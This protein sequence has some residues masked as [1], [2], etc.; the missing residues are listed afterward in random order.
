[1]TDNNEACPEC[2][3]MPTDVEPHGEGCTL[4][5]VKGTVYMVGYVG[6][7]GTHYFVTSYASGLPGIAGGNII[8]APCGIVR[9]DES[10][11]AAETFRSVRQ[12]ELYARQLPTQ[13]NGPSI[14]LPSRRRVMKMS[15]RLSRVL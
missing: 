2:F 4:A 13:K 7:D 15:L 1:M 11:S 3:R 9:Y 8:A 12:A 6:S 14:G 5:G 10:P